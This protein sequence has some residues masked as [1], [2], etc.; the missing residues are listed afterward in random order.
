MQNVWKNE[1]KKISADLIKI[2]K[3][4]IQIYCQ[5]KHINTCNTQIEE[6][7]GSLHQDSFF[8]LLFESN[9]SNSEKKSLK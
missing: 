4:T 5:T 2:L 9:K 3:L 8:F 7:Q 1:W 6:I